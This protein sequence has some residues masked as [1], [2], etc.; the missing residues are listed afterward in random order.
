MQE[1][2]VDK[3]M[4]GVAV[5]SLNR[6]EKR[7]ALNRTLMEELCQAFEALENDPSQRAIILKGEGKVFCAGLDLS[8]AA[9]Q[10]KVELSSQTVA[11]MLKT[12]HACPLVTIAAVH[13]AALAGGGG[14]AAAC[15]FV[16][17]EEGTVFGFPETRRGLVA[18][19]V[20]ALLSGQ[21]SPRHLKEL[22][23]L[24]RQI[25]AERALEIGLINSVA[26]RGTLPEAASVAAK[27]A[28]LGAPQAT[29][30]TKELIE[31]LSS[32]PFEKFQSL[33]EQ[34]H[35]EARRSE[36]AKE[37]VEAF[38]EKRDPNWVI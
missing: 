13:G 1:V 16:V 25:T 4:K 6:P 29:A 30:K 33:A 22:L 8:E 12:V 36:E 9:D 2:I 35:N 34:V 14:L 11:R 19:Q 3:S 20:A 10:E 24:G 37:G 7:N 26:K 32:S 31:K 27:E 21:I 17:A 18:A 23:V 5:V 15:D 38:F 28:L